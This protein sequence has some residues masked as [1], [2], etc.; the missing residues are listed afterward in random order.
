VILLIT[1]GGDNSSRAT[2]T[3]AQNGALGRDRRFYAIGIFDEND[4]IATRSLTGL[5]DETGGGRSSRMRFPNPRS[6]SRS[7]AT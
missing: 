2:L 7:R 3:D 6:A 1:D 5:A 4:A